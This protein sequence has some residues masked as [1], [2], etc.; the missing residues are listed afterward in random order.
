MKHESRNN[1]PDRREEDNVDI[2]LSS[3]VVRATRTSEREKVMAQRIY[4]T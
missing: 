2:P 4:I 1:I 3:E